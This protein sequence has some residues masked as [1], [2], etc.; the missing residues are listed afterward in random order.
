MRKGVSSVP[1]KLI[2]SGV[3]GS[4]LERNSLLTHLPDRRAPGYPTATYIQIITPPSCVTQSSNVCVPDPQSGSLLYSTPNGPTN[5]TG[6][7]PALGRPPVTNNEISVCS[8]YL[9][10]TVE[11]RC[12]A[13]FL[14]AVKD[15]APELTPAD[16]KQWQR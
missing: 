7:R 15:I 6:Q 2:L 9:Q 1:E 12:D 11:A 16:W 10:V 3:G 13:T 8:K 5:V 4:T 14:I